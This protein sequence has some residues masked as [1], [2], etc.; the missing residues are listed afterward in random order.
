MSSAIHP[1]PDTAAR[2]VPPVRAD[3][4]LAPL[5]PSIVHA[6]LAPPIALAPHAPLAPIDR[7]ADECPTDNPFFVTTRFNR[8]ET[9]TS[10]PGVLGDAPALIAFRYTESVK[11]HYV[12][13]RHRDIGSAYGIAVAPAEPAVY[14]G[15]YLKRGSP[16]ASGGPGAIY[17]VDLRTD[18][19]RL[20][21][22]VPGVGADP[23]DRPEAWPDHNARDAVGYRGLG[24]LDITPDGRSLY[25]MNLRDHRIY[26][27]D[28]ESRLL[29]STISTADVGEGWAADARPFGLFVDNVWLYHGIVRTPDLSAPAP[30]PFEAYVYRSTLGGGDM[31]RV[32]TIRLDADRGHVVRAVPAR[33]LPWRD[34]ADTID[35]ERLDAIAPQPILADIERANDGRLVIG[36]RDRFGDMTFN[37][38]GRL[39][40]DILGPGLP[41]GELEGLGAGD[42]LDSAALGG[43][44]EPRPEFFDQD[45][46]VGGAARFDEIALGGLAR[47]LVED[48]TVASAA[49]EWVADGAGALWLENDTGDTLWRETL[50]TTASRYSFGRT[51]GLGDVERLCWFRGAPTPPPGLTPSATWTASPTPSATPSPTSTSTPSPTATP[52]ETFSPTSTSTTQPSSTP[53]PTDTRPPSPTMTPT[54]TATAIPS[55]TA[56]ATPTPTE[57]PSPT[58]PPAPIYLPISGRPPRCENARRPVDA[59]LVLDRSTSMERVIGAGARSKSEAALD[60]ARRFVE[61]LSLRPGGEVPLD[62]VALVGFNDAAWIESALSERRSLTLIGLELLGLRSAEGTRLDL[63]FEMGGRA[64]FAGGDIVEGGLVERSRALILLTDGLP[65]RVPLPVSGG[66]QEDTV[67]AVA[68]AQRARGITIYTIGLGAPGDVS[69]DLLAAAAGAP[70]RYYRSPTGDDLGAIYAEIAAAVRVCR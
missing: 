44:V 38:Q 51:G 6:P 37:D 15:A 49:Q 16:F 2:S 53:A 13:A 23:H 64:L 11:E 63:A 50:Y 25:A 69:D 45:H 39:L 22:T 14:V 65:N 12:L 54:R 5:T 57:L 48:R 17:R 19:V 68:Q 46:G 70:E 34:G 31:R 4:P 59:A 47:V 18:E 35:P 58:R 28:V 26:R 66:R 42:L 29:E 24:D 67:L 61:E 52:T 33:W 27:Y 1:A 3:V 21:N 32:A 62:R 7:F 56:T 55:A 60:A 8:P 36:M 9:R 41:P 10:G 40:P 43:Y 20:W 30:G